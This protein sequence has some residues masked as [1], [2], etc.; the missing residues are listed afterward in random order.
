MTSVAPRQPASWQVIGEE[1]WQLH[2]NGALHLSKCKGTVSGCQ[3]WKLTAKQQLQ[4]EL[5]RQLRTATRWLQACLLLQ[6]SHCPCFSSAG[7]FP[8][9]FSSVGSISLEFF[10]AWSPCLAAPFNAAFSRCDAPS[11]EL[12]VFPLPSYPLAFLPSC[13]LMTKGGD[14]RCAGPV[15]SRVLG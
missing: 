5:G 3:R 6:P 2:I 4:R 14:Q 13:L 10:F 11:V 15:I 1:T 7:S 9:G 12:G 8:L